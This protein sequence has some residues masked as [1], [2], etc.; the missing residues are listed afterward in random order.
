ML[1]VFQ[2]VNFWVTRNHK[3]CCWTWHASIINL[4]F[5]HLYLLHFPSRCQPIAFYLKQTVQSWTK[6][7]K[8]SVMLDCCPGWLKFFLVLIYLNS[9][10]Q[11]SWKER[12]WNVWM[13]V[14]GVKWW[15]LWSGGDIF[16]LVVT[17]TIR[18]ESW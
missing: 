8:M 17:V 9:P 3:N 5:L 7:W 12:F 15:H 6:T 14:Q 16:E 1:L 4:I 18:L 13:F 11:T 10:S 2:S